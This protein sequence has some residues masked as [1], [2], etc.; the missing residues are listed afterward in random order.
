MKLTSLVTSIS[1]VLLAG[2]HSSPPSVP[3]QPTVAAEAI[4][5]TSSVSQSGVLLSGV[6]HPHLEADIAAQISGP[7]AVLMKHEGDTVRRGEVLVRLH[8]PALSAGV[9]QANA[10][11]LAAEQQR[12]AAKAQ[13]GLA[14]DTL[15]RYQQLR[16]RHSVTAHELEQTRAQ[17]AAAQA[18]EQTALCQVA[19][20]KEALAVQ[21]ANAADAVLLAPFDGVV[22]QRMADPGAMALPGVPLLHVQST[23]GA[24]VQFTVPE[25]MVLAL[26]PGQK[27][28]VALGQDEQ[29]AIVTLLSPSGDAASHSFLVKAALPRSNAWKSGT[30]VSVTLPNTKGDSA[31]S[32]PASALVEQGGL[33]AVLVL[34]PEN[35]AE[36]RYVTVGQTLGTQRQ[37]LTGVKAGDRILTHGNLNLAGRTIEVRP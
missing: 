2:C 7:V 24:E 11:V 37:I 1:V 32:V 14:A 16:E 13:A 10:A 35:Q 30:V 3:Q 31:L 33:R 18:Q 20:A 22:T 12:T 15:A 17:S 36:V 21:R 25:P 27:Q 34:N 29:T 26:R 6:V 28:P 8:V 4:T 23:E 5:V 19:V 9:A